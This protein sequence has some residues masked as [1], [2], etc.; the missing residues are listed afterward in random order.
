[1]R[2]AGEGKAVLEERKGEEEKERER[3]C[4]P[5]KRAQLTADVDSGSA[6]WCQGMLTHSHAHR[7][8]R[9]HTTELS[10]GIQPRAYASLDPCNYTLV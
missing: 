1:M 9:T 10:A 4:S 7:H 8:T 5:L 6:S 3:R 2:T